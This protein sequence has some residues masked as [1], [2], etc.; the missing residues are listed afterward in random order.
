MQALC[1]SVKCMVSAVGSRISTL[2]GGFIL[3]LVSGLVLLA[4]AACNPGGGASVLPAAP[5]QTP[6]DGAAPATAT[7]ASNPADPAP[8][9]TATAAP[10]ESAPEPT[11]EARLRTFRLAP[12][13]SEA[14]FIVDEV[15]LGR[16]NTVVGST[17][18]VTGTIQVDLNDFRQT[19][20]SPIQV[21][22]RSLAT[23]N[24]FRNR[25]IQRQIL[26]SQRD[27]YRY[28]V[29]TPTAIEGL[30]ETVNLG[31]PF[32]FQIV[33]DLTIRD[34]TSP[35]TFEVTVTPVSETELT[36][37]ARTT[38]TR[39]MFD[40]RIPNVPGVADVSEDVQ[41]ELEFVAVA[42]EGTGG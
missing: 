5:A 10:T 15:L 31:E 11:P 23:D 12:G 17:D 20:V 35:V 42:E 1:S 28:I 25:S 6:A 9:P 26:Q 21:D 34:I 36:G 37:L 24:R 16:P 29:F 32:T 41:L 8:T 7:P 13:Q 38:V 14:R 27:E 3:A 33:G 19:Q 18:Q 4:L 40:L 30:P 22:A 2:R 39:S